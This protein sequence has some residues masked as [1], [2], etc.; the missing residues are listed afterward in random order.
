MLLTTV[1]FHHF[2]VLLYRFSFIVSISIITTSVKL[3]HLNPPIPLSAL[4]LF[5]APLS[6]PPPIHLIISLILI[7]LIWS[8]QL[9]QLASWPLWSSWPSS[10]C[11][12]QPW[13]YSNPVVLGL[14][15]PILPSALLALIIWPLRTNIF[16]PNYTTWWTNSTCFSPSCSSPL[17]YQIISSVFCF[18][19]FPWILC[20]MMPKGK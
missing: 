6:H 17:R 7:P 19:V 5:I 8:L 12:H 13:P 1:I 2:G 9:P 15:L 4:E 16:E 10:S 14:A 11:P 20:L 3:M 18:L